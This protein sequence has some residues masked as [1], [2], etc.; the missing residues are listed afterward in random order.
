MTCGNSLRRISLFAVGLIV[1]LAGKAH[2]GS[3][4]GSAIEVSGL[5]NSIPG[6]DYITVTLNGFSATNTSDVDVVVVAPTG[7]ALVLLGGAGGTSPVGP[8][9]IMFDDTAA[10]TVPPGLASSGSFKP[11]QFGQVGSFPS[12]GP[13]LAYHSPATFGTSILGNL[14]AA[15]VFTGINL[16]GTWS[17]YAMDT[18]SGDSTDIANG[19]R[20]NIT[21]PGTNPSTFTNSTPIVIPTAPEPGTLILATFGLASLA[22]WGWRRRKRSR[23]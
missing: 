17:L 3:I 16:N 4:N 1:A 15:G 22:A 13:G 14:N 20:L 8:F 21:L 19:W 23:G 7:A 2:A 9:N 10:S 18:V 6:N 11:T 5:P 12:P